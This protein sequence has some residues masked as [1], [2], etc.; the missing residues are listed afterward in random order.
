MSFIRPVVAPISTFPQSVSVST[1]SATDRQPNDYKWQTA[2]RTAND[3]MLMW[4]T[5]DHN[6]WY[7]LSADQDIGVIRVFNP[8]TDTVSNPHFP[9][10]DTDAGTTATGH[11]NP[12]SNQDNLNYVYLATDNLLCIPEYGVYD[13][14][15]T[16]TSPYWGWTNGNNG[17][18]VEGQTQNTNSW[19]A[20]SYWSDFLTNWSTAA[21]RKNSFNAWCDSQSIGIC[22]GNGV[23]GNQ[24]NLCRVMWKNGAQ[25]TTKVITITNWTP[26]SYNRNVIAIKGNFAYYGGGVTATPSFT[27]KFWKLDLA[28]VNSKSDGGSTD[29]SA[30]TALADMPIDTGDTS[31]NGWPQLTYDSRFDVLVL[32][33][34]AAVYLYNIATDTWSGNVAPGGYSMGTGYVMGIY[35]TGQQA[36]YYRP[37]G[38][39]GTIKR[40][41][42]S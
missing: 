37:D 26:A 3:R 17:A 23:S 8:A 33:T 25:W 5:G 13:L 16:G 41:V 27:R 21:S 14:D 32:A 42:L 4:G 11:G 1:M 6:F 28:N 22:L 7:G 39:T 12:V 34:P 19:S 20:G 18:M 40:L 31:G 15:I 36:H 29:G 24:D 38:T 9:A 2:Y 10:N 30:L 35:S